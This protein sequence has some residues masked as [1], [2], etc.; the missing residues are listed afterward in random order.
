M[1][2]GLFSAD[3]ANADAL[4]AI[5]VFRDSPC[6]L[7][8]LALRVL[9]RAFQG[10]IVGGRNCCLPELF[11]HEKGLHSATCTTLRSV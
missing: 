1:V 5:Q 10:I 6:D 3:L 11:C 9:S 4:I 7:F 8:H 2:P